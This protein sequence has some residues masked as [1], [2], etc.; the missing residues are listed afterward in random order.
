MNDK[1]RETHNHK[2]Q[3]GQGLV[4]YALI[5]IFAAVAAILIINLLGPSISNVFSRFVRN[6]PVA[7]PSLVNYT[8]PAT[9]TSTPTIDPNATATN[10]PVNTPTATPVTPT[11]TNTNTPTSTA[12]PTLQPSETPTATATP[13]CPFG[14]HVIPQNGSVRVQA[15]DYMCGGEGTAYHDISTGGSG[16]CNS[17][18]RTDEANPGVELENTSDTG[19]GCNVGWIRNG[20]WIRYEVIAPQAFRYEFVLRTAATSNGAIRIRVTNSLGTIE[21]ASITIPNT[22]GWQSWTDVTAS[23]PN[24]SLIAG[25]NTVEIFM[26]NDGF[27]LNYFDIRQFVPTPTPQPSSGDVLFVVGNT[28][29]NANDSRSDRAI[30]DRLE[31][32]GYTVTIVDDAA[33][34]TSDANGKALVIISSTVNAGSVGNK[35][36][37]VTVPVIVWDHALLDNMRMTGNNG[38]NHGTDGNEHNINIVNNTHQLAAGLSSGLVRVTTNN[39]TFS[40]GQP[41][42]NAIRIATIDNNS[43]R[44]VIFAYDTGA[45]MFNGLNAPARRV[46]FFL[47][48]RTAERLNDDGWSLFDAAVDWSTGN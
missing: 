14:P 19:G 9:F 22:N 15:E 11:A 44:Y 28:N 2:Q 25:S 45:Q 41:N 10:T 40:W 13:P 27:N 42:N 12:T 6:A 3:A 31:G 29:M 1:Q 26:E 17:S 8:P 4:E 33:S 39:R 20:E 37:N 48:N 46:G 24:L 23:D 5:L 34:Q 38:G 43:N 36:R 32:R 47:E 35:F 7:P 30:R 18:Y 16:S 21:T